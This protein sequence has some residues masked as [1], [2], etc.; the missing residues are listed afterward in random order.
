[1]TFTVE[2]PKLIAESAPNVQFRLSCGPRSVGLEAKLPKD[3]DWTI[4]LSLNSDG[5]LLWGR[6]PE[7]LGLP[8]TSDGKLILD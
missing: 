3:P 8:I 4:L 7:K 2:P 5:L 6:I 1:M